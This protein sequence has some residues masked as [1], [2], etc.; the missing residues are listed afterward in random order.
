MGP[1]LQWLTRAQLMATE[2][3]LQIRQ[4]AMSVKNK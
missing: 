4:T 3:G 1:V 2:D